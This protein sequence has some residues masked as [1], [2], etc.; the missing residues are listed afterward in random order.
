MSLENQFDVIVVGRFL[1][2]SWI[3]AELQKKNF[4]VMLIDL[5]SHLG[6]WTPEDIEGPFGFFKTDILKQSY[7]EKRNNEEADHEVENG[8]TIWRPTGPLEFKGPL[9]NF[10]FQKMGFDQKSGE[11]FSKTQRVEKIAPEEYVQNFDKYWPL[12]LSQ[13]LAS[14]RF[15][16]LQQ[17]FEAGQGLPF[18]S[19]FFIRW[20]SRNTTE[21]SMQWLKTLKVRTTTTTNVIDLSHGPKGTI[22]GLELKGEL[23]GL[24]RCENIIWCLT[25]E[26]TYFYNSLLGQEIFPRGSLESQW[27]WMR[28]RL[29]YENNE[30]MKSLPLH[31]CTVEN[32]NLSM[33]HDNMILWQKTAS[34]ELIDAW[35]RLPTVQ[36]FNKTYLA[37]YGD[38]IK[39]NLQNRVQNSAIEVHSFPQE[40]YYTYHQMGPSQHPIYSFVESSSKRRRSV[41]KNLS[42]FSNETVDIYSD[43]V[44]QLAQQ[45]IIDQYIREREI[46]ESKKR[47]DQQ[48]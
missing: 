20:P 29:K 18:Q 48:P 32:E 6:A 2:G 38:K 30:R 26:E 28:Y 14:T 5:S 22:Q 43:E 23:S 42:L 17:S 10:Y 45:E 36:R 31:F 1:Q 13:H 34:N 39:I 27:S 46:K 12:S 35:V 40:Y 44:L 9:S 21:K 15:M 19:S 11:S 33:T 24:V 25:S 37:N 4:N 7:L 16:S 3:S 41:F 8:F 47:K